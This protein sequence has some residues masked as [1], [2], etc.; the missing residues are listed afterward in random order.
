MDPSHN[1]GDAFSS[2]PSST[3]PT[4][5]LAIIIICLQILISLATYPFLPALVPSHWNAAG[6]IDSYMP[7][8]LNA[9]LLPAISL[10]TYLLV[11]LLLAA[12]PK[13]GAQNQR[14][15]LP[16][17]NIILV[18]VLLLMLVVQ[19]ITIATALRVPVDVP[20]VI[21]LSI[22]ALLILLGNYLGKLRR[23]FWAGIRTPWTLAS[24]T[25]WE[26]THRLGG[27]LFVAAGVL[28][29]IMAFIAPLRIWGM[30]VLTLL[31]VVILFAYSYVVY[32]R[33]EARGG[34]TLSP[35]FDNEG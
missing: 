26:R 32:Q 27:W 20:L 8:A 13:L 5:I 22:G 34:E 29:I 19:L 2:L 28:D 14:A 15:T 11:R 23:N 30:L 1:S 7:K 24:S 12:G 18:G 10:G 9:I 6:Q 31:I 3:R 4:T 17:V 21:S 25:V 16:V 35:P 33:S